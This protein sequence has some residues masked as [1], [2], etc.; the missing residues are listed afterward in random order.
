LSS[1]TMYQRRYA[2]P[3]YE[4]VIGR[5]V[6]HAADR[7]VSPAALAIAWVNAHPAVTAS[8]IGARNL[9]Q[10]EDTLG[11]LDIRLAPEEREAVSAL[12]P[13]PPLATDRED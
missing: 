7:G 6:S 13:A 1:N 2:D 3:L 5:F 11:C 4:E 9:D 8:I 12:S 10:L